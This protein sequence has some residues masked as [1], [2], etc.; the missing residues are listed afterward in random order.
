MCGDTYCH[1]CGPAQGNYHCQQCGKWTDEGGCEDPDECGRLD[2][3]CEDAMYRE[4]LE[5]EQSAKQR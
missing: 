5:I 1:S 2:K 3:L 4:Y